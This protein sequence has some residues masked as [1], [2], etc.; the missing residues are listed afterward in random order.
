M[1]NFL[2]NIE[3][4]IDAKARVFVPA[5]FRKVLQSSAQTVLILRKDLFQDCLVLYPESV[6]D[7]VVEQL[8]SRLSQWDKAQ[9]QLF[10]QFVADAERLEM[11]ANGRILLPKRCMQMTNIASDITFLGVGDTIEL[12]TRE[13]FEK[14]LIPAEDFSLR[15]QDLMN[16]NPGRE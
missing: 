1:L 3:A 13:A 8:R 14:S 5:A 6:W 4:K 12:W 11:D 15:I 7:E 16:N 2:G 9:Q 10:R